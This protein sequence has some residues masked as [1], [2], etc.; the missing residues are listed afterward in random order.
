MVLDGS[1]WTQ[2]PVPSAPPPWLDPVIDLRLL[3]TPDLDS[4]T[5]TRSPVPSTPPP[6]LDP[7][8]DLRLLD[9]PDLDTSTWTQTSPPVPQTPAQRDLSPLSVVSSG[10]NAEMTQMTGEIVGLKR[11]QAKSIAD[12][13]RG[14]PRKKARA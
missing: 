12:R 11:K 13:P 4:S 6:Q 2:S 14:R 3:D 1:T 5:R 7:G 10:S 8:S 9:T